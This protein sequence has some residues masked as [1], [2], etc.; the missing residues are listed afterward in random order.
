[1]TI[2][3]PMTQ[4]QNIESLVWPSKNRIAIMAKAPSNPQP[5]IFSVSAS[6]V[7]FAEVLASS[8]SACRA[9]VGCMYSLPPEVEMRGSMQQRCLVVTYKFTGGGP[10]NEP[11]KTH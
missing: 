10:G 6:S 5:K 1:M 8:D 2:S 11:R 4:Y 3:A 9:L 7:C